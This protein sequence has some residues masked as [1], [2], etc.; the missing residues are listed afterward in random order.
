MCGGY[1]N[2]KPNK[3]FIWKAKNTKIVKMTLKNNNVIGKHEI[4]YLRFNVYFKDKILTH[5]SDSQKW[6]KE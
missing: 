4:F 3:K 1:W 2:Y 5:I 6:M